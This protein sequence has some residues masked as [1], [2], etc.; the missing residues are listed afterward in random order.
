M[1]A[2]VQ[3]SLSILV[4]TKYTMPWGAILLVTVFG[5]TEFMLESLTTSHMYSWI[6]YLLNYAYASIFMLTHRKLH[7][8]YWASFIIL[9]L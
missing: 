1:A 2:L 7:I 8:S 4:P 6:Y 3:Y 9:V 5:L